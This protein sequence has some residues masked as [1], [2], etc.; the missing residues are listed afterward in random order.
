MP[1]RG[2]NITL[3]NSAKQKGDDPLMFVEQMKKSL[4]IFR[5]IRIRRMYAEILFMS[6]QNLIKQSNC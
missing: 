2:R 3:V 5:G 1:S 4:P 6:I